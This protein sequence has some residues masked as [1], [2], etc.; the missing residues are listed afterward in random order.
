MARSAW[1]SGS[2][3]MAR[4]A[5]PSGSSGMARSAW[6]SGSSGMARSA[7]PSGPSA[8]AR[9]ALAGALV[10]AAAPVLGGCGTCPPGGAP[11][12][13]RVGGAVG[14]GSGGFWREIWLSL[15]VTNLFCRTPE[16][17]ET[18][19]ASAPAAGGEEATDGR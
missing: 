2:S 10:A 5:W 12:E 14:G 15:D 6:P 11:V 16:E 17:D 4:S 19:D 7:W 3:G 1:P 13:P 18:E 9:A 8:L